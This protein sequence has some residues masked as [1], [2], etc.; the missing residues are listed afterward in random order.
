MAQWLIQSQLL[1]PA[2][3]IQTTLRL[4]P[5]VVLTVKL[6]P[7][8][9]RCPARQQQPLHYVLGDLYRRREKTEVDEQLNE[10]HQDRIGG[11]IQAHTA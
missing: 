1:L 9:S 6:N 10:S 7:S 2:Y 5:K 8:N 11:S 3:Y 4:P